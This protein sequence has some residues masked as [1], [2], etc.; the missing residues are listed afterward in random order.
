MKKN[1]ILIVLFIIVGICSCKKDSIE[2]PITYSSNSISDPTI[3]VYTR[4]G[5]M[6][7]SALINNLIMRFQDKIN[8]LESDKIKGT[9]VVTYVSKDSVELTIDNVKEDRLRS[10]HEIDGVIYLEKQDTSMSGFGPLFKIEDVYKYNPIYYKE[11]FAPPGSAYSK[12]TK[13]KECYYLI[14]NGGKLNIPMFD[15][16]W[17]WD[18]NTGVP[19]YGNN[20]SF[21]EDGMGTFLIGDTAIIQQ[22]LIEMN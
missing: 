19:F 10:V 9:V 1:Q 16:L 13:F 2:Y 17:I 3:K 4:D 15:F 14:R 7:S 18:T 21:K 20:N 5:E 11:F 12:Y 8:K 6:T 22:Y